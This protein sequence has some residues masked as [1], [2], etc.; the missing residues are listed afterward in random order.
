[1]V[2]KHVWGL[3]FDPHREWQ[4]IRDERCSIGKC[5]ASNVL[6]LA[7]IPPI[8]AYFGSTLAGW[9]IGTGEAIKLT[10]DSALQIAFAFYLALMATVFIMGKAIHWMAQTFDAKPEL[11]KCVVLASYI[12]TPLFVSG[13]A[14]IYPV[15][16]INMLIG[17]I[18]VAYTV[19]LLYLGIPI[20][21]Q[22]PKEQGFIFSTSILTVGLI[23]LV[24]ILVITVLLWS[25]GIAPA[26]TN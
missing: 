4:V 1:M 6:I 18:A 24:S 8:F 17:L 20:V 16:W 13:I 26:Y 23:G 2:L 11:A 9:R 12:A 15:L 3:F 5:Y 14:A 22:I 19:Y 21:M 10:H 25:S 7:A